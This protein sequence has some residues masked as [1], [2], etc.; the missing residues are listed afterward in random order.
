MNKP[1]KND[2]ESSGP[3]M[4]EIGDLRNFRKRVYAS[5]TSEA[6]M[7]TAAV[8]EIQS[9]LLKVER[10]TLL[11]S[12]LRTTKAPR[13]S[14]PEKSLLGQRRGNQTRLR[15]T[16]G[17]AFMVAGTIL[18]FPGLSVSGTGSAETVAERGTLTNQA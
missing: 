13:I 8:L 16:L 14:D 4:S 15:L 3:G 7:R 9:M 2:A 5:E 11:C 18:D 6:A 17:G 10:T 12:V 1:N